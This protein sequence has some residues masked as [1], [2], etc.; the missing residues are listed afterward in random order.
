MKSLFWAS[1]GAPK[2]LPEA[3]GAEKKFMVNFRGGS[4]RISQRDFTLPRGSGGRFGLHFGLPGGSFLA[5]F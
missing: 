1:R 2:S 5:L 3:S 4:G